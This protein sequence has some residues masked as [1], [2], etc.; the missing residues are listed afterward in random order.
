MLCSLTVRL[1]FSPVLKRRLKVIFI[2]INCVTL[3]IWWSYSIYHSVRELI[4]CSLRFYKNC[5]RLSQLQR[6]LFPP[7]RLHRCHAW[8]VMH[9]NDV[10]IRASLTA[11]LAVTAVDCQ[12]FPKM[13]NAQWALLIIQRQSFNTQVQKLEDDIYC[14]HSAQSPLTKLWCHAFFA[15]VSPVSMCC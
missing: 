12:V 13:W 2:R 11:F 3:L 10:T 15:G 8:P 4:L 7:T 6:R 14:R 9:C 5:V 1:L